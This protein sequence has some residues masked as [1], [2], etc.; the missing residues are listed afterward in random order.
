MEKKK[1]RLHYAWI[2]LISCCAIEAGGLGGIMDAA[3]VF[4]VPVTSDLGFGRADIALYLSVNMFVQAFIMPLSGRI[5]KKYNIKV[6]L[7]LAFLVVFIA[8]AAMS[9]YT[10]PWQWWISGIFVGIGGGFVFLMPA[11]ILI[12][13]WFIKRRGLA[14]AVGMSFSGIG[15]AIF[16]PLFAS[17]IQAFG[18]RTGYIAVA[19]ILAVVVL[20]FTIFVVR[21]D[22]KDMGLKPYG[23]SEEDER[24]SLELAAEK[25][26]VPGVPATKAVRTVP[27]VSIFLFGGLIT[28]YL[29]LNSH[30][31][32][33][34][35]T[36]GFTPIIAS[37]VISAV[38]VGNVVEKLVMGWVNDRI[39]VQ[40]SVNVQLGMV[41]LGLLG[42]LFVGNNL[43]LLYISAFLFGAQNSLVAV[44]APLVIRQVF[45]NKDF[46]LLY[47]YMRMGVIFGSVG[48]TVIGAFYDRTGSYDPAII[49][50]L[51]IVV[52][53]F[54]AVRVAVSWRSRLQWEDLPDDPED[55]KKIRNAR[56]SSS[57]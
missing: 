54:I 47:A 26:A 38:M 51:V 30:L 43:A 6:V 5:L 42:F 33:L 10:E 1:P 3:G 22:P 41:A 28:Y 27:F 11:P 29:G 39:G 4:F 50:G 9:F 7:T 49:L 34:A 19:I 12:N 20:P 40:L 32:A 18:W 13:N 57:Y 48:P 24:L 16:S 35:M 52:V 17:I 21:F 23:W 44:S 8:V 25:K 45:G 37:T 55:A 46:V 56:T 53:A 14:L 31:P 15:G 36:H 2:I